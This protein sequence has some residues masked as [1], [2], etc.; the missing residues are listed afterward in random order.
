M[1]QVNAR[2]AS[3]LT[4]V[5]H[6]DL[7]NNL[8]VSMDTT[9]VKQ[10]NDGIRRKRKNEGINR[11]KDT[12]VKK[13]Y[14]LEEF[15]GVEVALIICKHGRYTTYRSRDHKTWP[16]SMAEIVSEVIAPLI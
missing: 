16:P 14:E 13:A 11:R 15:D 3:K 10:K 5:D 8:L 9:N 2:S 12:L 1:P 7:C 4:W 6:L